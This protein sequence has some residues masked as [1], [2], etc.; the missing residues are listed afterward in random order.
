MGL[1]SRNER[2]PRVID[3]RDGTSAQEFGRPTPCPACGGHGYL[4]GIDVKGGVMFQHCT[5]CSATW[6]TSEAD[7]SVQ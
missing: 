3:L 1:F 7:V 6:E 4:D 2:K 5:D